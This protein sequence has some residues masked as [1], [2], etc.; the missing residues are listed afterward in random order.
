MSETQVETIYY[1]Y[2]NTYPIKFLAKNNVTEAAVDITGNT[3]TLDVYPSASA[4]EADKIFSLA[5]TVTSGSGGAYQFP[6]TTT[7][8]NNE[9]DYYYRVKMDD[10]NESTIHEGP[11][12]ITNKINKR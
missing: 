7:E 6:M 1:K 12:I 3:F 8:S 10:G 4:V 2:G 5:G 11:F 9:G